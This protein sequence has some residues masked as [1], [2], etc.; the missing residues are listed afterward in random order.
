KAWGSVICYN[1]EI[2]G[3]R[4]GNP[5]VEGT[6]V[7]SDTASPDFSSGWAKTEDAIRDK[8]EYLYCGAHTAGDG[9]IPVAGDKIFHIN[10]N[11]HNTLESAASIMGCGGCAMVLPTVNS[12]WEGTADPNIGVKPYATRR[13]YFSVLLRVIDPVSG[14]QLYPYPDNPDNMTVVYYAVDKSGAIVTRLYPGQKKDEFF[15]DRALQHP[16]VA[17]EGEVQKEFGWAAVP[18]DADWSAG[19]RYVYTLNYS[20]GIGLHDPQDPDPGKPIVMN[21]PVSWGVAVDSWKDAEKSEDFDPDVN[22]P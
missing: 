22:V 20:D 21:A 11:E 18:V 8:V 6:F 16:Y 10:R 4:L 9:E 1:F 3:V 14:R 19:K 2:A 15:T 17:A 7:F 12:K 5:V 13:M